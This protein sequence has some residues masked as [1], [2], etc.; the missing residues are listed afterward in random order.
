MSEGF[1]LNEMIFDEKGEMIDYRILEV[2][3]AFYTTADYMGPV[4]GNVATKLYGMSPE[5]INVFWREH[6]SRNTVQ[7]TEMRS[8]TTDQTF[9]VSTSPFLKDQFVTSFFDITERKRAEEELN[10]VQLFLNSVIEHSPTA[11]WI[12]D[13]HGTLMRMNQACR[14]VLQ[15][16]DEEVVGK[17]NILNDDQIKAQGYMPQVLNVFEK[18]EI[19]RFR[20]TYNT[21]DVKG[22]SFENTVKVVLDVSISAIRD[23]HGK[24]TNAIIQHVNITQLDMAKKELRESE[25]RYRLLA[26]TIPE[27]L[28][29]QQD[30]RFIFANNATLKLFGAAKMED[31]IGTPVIER[32]HPQYRQ[33]VTDRI[34]GPGDKEEA[35]PMI[36]EIYLRLDGSPVNVEVA[37]NRLIMNGKATMQVVAHDITERKKIL[38]SLRESEQRY[39]RSE[40][41]LREA[42]SIAQVGSWTWDLKT[43]EVIWSDEMYR[44]FGI[45]KYSYTGRLGDVI[46]NVIHPDDLQVVLPSNAKSISEKPIEYRI[47]LPNNIIRHIWAKT[48]DFILDEAGNPI[49]MSGIAQDVTERKKIE[50]ALR[51]AYCRAESIIEGTQAGTWEWN[52]QTGETVFNQKWAQI[53]GYTLDELAPV[54][55]KTWERF[56]HPEDLKRSDELLERHFAGELP[57]YESE[58]R[59]KHKDGRWV[60]VLDRGRVITRTSDG[61][62]LMM[63]GT[64]QDITAQKLAREELRAS[65]ERFRSMFNNHAAVML[66]I[67]PA[68]GAIISANPSAADFYGYPE[69]H[70]VQMNIFELNMLPPEETKREMEKARTEARNYFVFVHRLANGE[71]RTVEVHSSPLHFENQTILFSIIHDISERKALEK[72]LKTERDYVTQIINIMGQGLTVTNAEGRFEFVNP[73]YASLFGYQPSDLI[74]KSPADIS[75]P[76]E[77]AVLSEQ[78]KRRIKGQVSTYESRLVRTDGSIADVLITGAPREIDGKY[79]GSIAVITDL[80][81]QKQIENKLRESEDRFRSFL[82][83]VKLISVQGYG[84]DGTTQYWNQASERLYGYSSQEAIGKNLL[85]LIIPPEMRADVRQAMQQMAETGEPTPPSDLLL[86]RK[87]GS[88]VMVFSSHAIVQIPGC[89]QELFCI[90]IDITERKAAEEKIRLLNVELEQLAGT[91]GLTGIHNH[92][93]LLQLAEREF[94][95]AMRYQPPLAMMF[96]DID[97]FKQINDVFGH[98]LGDEALKLTIQTIC[99]NLRSADLIGRYGGD[100][101]VILLPQTR[102]QDA[103]PLAERIHA[104]IAEMRLDTIKGPLTLTI[105]IG[106]AESIHDGSQPDS[107]ENLLLRAD[108]ALYAAKQGGRD[109]TVIGQ[110]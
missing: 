37:A 16:R 38:D 108:Q 39:Y 107:V 64:H 94:D 72:E 65:E 93:S 54:S 71:I 21:A 34:G 19:A 104:S 61:K 28:F 100:E 18:G 105:S 33:I 17:Y 13:E 92:R 22:L 7:I 77:D 109:R 70:L 43:Q 15:L 76:K 20:I 95:I 103:L 80:T 29:L 69:S 30:G 75:L 56:A 53:I 12:S 81:E 36:E 6:K 97:H 9:I 14:D 11:L 42:Q 27:P 82:E 106:I 48:G 58:S 57:N 84:L 102:M 40:A 60:W 2:N 8:P 90:D 78:R 98:A 25:E 99:A 91:D 10:E 41:S 47:L 55:I 96:F 52:I 1:A 35:I 59:M 63:F 67:D 44:I 85:N 62:P 110:K 49:F 68:S 45:D 74:G 46:R 101:F 87:D 88:R 89:E 5:F 73:A 86:M 4:V 79:A 23:A 3:P 32:V 83:E 51:D 50:D 66:L 24:V 26:T 31:L